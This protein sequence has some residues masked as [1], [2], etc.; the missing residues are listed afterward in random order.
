MFILSVFLFLAQ[1]A[2]LYINIVGSVVIVYA[3][4]P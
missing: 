1:V 4:D 2:L 3:T